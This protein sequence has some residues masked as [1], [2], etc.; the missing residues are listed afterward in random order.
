MSRIYF[1]QFYTSFVEYCFRVVVRKWNKTN[2]TDEWHKFTTYWLDNILSEKDRNFIRF[3][4][5][6]KFY[7]SAEGLVCYAPNEDY[8]IK[9]RY[10][11]ALEKQFAIDGGLIDEQSEADRLGGRVNG[12]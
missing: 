12:I 11:F 1:R 6:E 10:L 5:D 2:L 8:E 4:F 9:R 3:V 7:N